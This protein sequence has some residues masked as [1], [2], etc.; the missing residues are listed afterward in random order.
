MFFVAAI[1]QQTRE[2]DFIKEFN[3]E[4]EA[5][6]FFVSKSRNYHSEDIIVTEAGSRSEFLS[7]FPAFNG[8]KGISNLIRSLF[9]G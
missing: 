6:R 5:I 3:N 9:G 1:N 4:Q 8:K 2:N 7:K